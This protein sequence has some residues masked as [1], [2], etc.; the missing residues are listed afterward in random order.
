MIKISLI[1]DKFE[2]D[3][4][5][6]FESV[7]NKDKAGQNIYLDSQ[8]KVQILKL[9]DDQSSVIGICLFSIMLGNVVL[10]KLV[11]D[12]NSEQNIEA[13]IEA[14]NQYAFSLFQ[15][16]SI[17]HTTL[18]EERKLIHALEITSCQYVG[19]FRN[20][21][22]DSEIFKFGPMLVF[23][24]T[25]SDFK[26]KKLDYEQ[27]AVHSYG[28]NNKNFLNKELLRLQ[29]QGLFQ[30]EVDSLLA[31]YL[32]N[33]SNKKILDIGSG[34]GNITYNLAKKNLNHTFCGVDITQD[35][36]EYA[37]LNFTNSNLSFK[38][39]DVF[40]SDQVLVENNIFLLRFVSQHLGLKGTFSLLEKIKEIKNNRSE[41]FTVIVSDIDDRS[42]I[43]EPPCSAYD[44][45]FKASQYS[46]RKHGGDRMI[47]AKI[48]DICNQLGL[49][50]ENFEVSKIDSISIGI[51]SFEK[52]IE[53]M[54]NDKI[55]VSFLGN[56]E[57][58]DQIS[59]E[60]REYRKKARF[61]YGS[62]FTY[63]IEG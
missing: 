17:W 8:E 53:P 22:F 18:I 62:L 43:F 23:E 30:S 39:L 4:I 40:T 57:I 10:C 1:E 2:L 60:I 44:L 25:E 35:F 16:K 13:C 11:L 31:N 33:Y 46:Q 14:I 37:T 58:Y 28:I 32:L 21:F 20:N 12:S 3:S 55:D 45:A 26:N 5:K 7:K 47:G 9:S 29:T 52:I 38:C 61:G 59:S 27:S 19:L 63:V 48:P 49:K 24:F 34:V 15:I 50:I 36:V 41:N 6:I 51:R 54:I 56:K 42:W